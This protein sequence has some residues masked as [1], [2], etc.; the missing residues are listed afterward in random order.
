MH[1]PSHVSHQNFRTFS[2]PA[3]R[4][5]PRQGI[6]SATGSVPPLGSSTRP[7]AYRCRG[8]KP[9]A[10]PPPRE[11]GPPEPPRALRQRREP[12]ALRPSPARSSIDSRRVPMSAATGL[13]I[14]GEKTSG[15][16]RPCLHLAPAAAPARTR[17]PTRRL[18]RAAPAHP[19]AR[20]QT[21]LRA[22]ACRCHVGSEQCGRSV[23]SRQL[24]KG[25]LNGQ[26]R[27]SS[28]LVD[29]L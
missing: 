2:W 8:T 21:R 9:A 19:I 29:C 17:D 3:S 4:T 13:Q 28:P 1:G 25:R 22:V 11:F 10:A 23:D 20:E 7:A 14:G 24:F 26:R 6:T 18:G 27:T 12:P 16:V 15:Q 5:R